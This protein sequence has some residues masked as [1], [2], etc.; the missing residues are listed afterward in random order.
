MDEPPAINRTVNLNAGAGNDA[1]EDLLLAGLANVDDRN[2]LRPQ[3]AEALPTIENGLWRLLPDGRMETTWRLRP[4]A[5]WHDGA[6]FSANDLLFTAR[7]GQDR[8]LPIRRARVF[9]LIDGFDAPDPQTLKVSWKRT[10]IYADTLF[11]RT[12]LPPMPEH[13]LGQAYA[14]EKPAFAHLPYWTQE[15]VGTGPFRVRDWVRGSHVTLEANERYV[16]GRPRVDQVEVRFIPDQNAL[17]ASLLAGAVELTLGRSLTLDPAIQVRDQWRAGTMELGFVNWF[18]IYPQLLTPSPGVIADVQLRRALLHAIDRQQMVESLQAG[19]ATVAHTR[20]HPSEPEYAEI[21]PLVARYD[22]DPR[23]AAQIIEG[24]GYTKGADGLYRDG[25][26]QR[27]SVE[28]RSGAGD[29]LTEK[30]MLSVADFWKRLG[31]DA[32]PFVLPPERDR[33]AEFRA[34]FPGF[35][36]IRQPNDPSSLEDFRSSAAPLPET[37]YQGRNRPRYINPEWD[38][39]IERHFTT[40]ARAE[41]TQ[42]LAQIESHIADRLIMMGLYYNT[43]PILFGNR[44]LNVTARKASDSTHSWNAEH[45]EIR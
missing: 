25:A 27:L 15:F 34:I 9:D 44:L 21:A 30:S 10:F 36:M 26:N 1:L 11:T 32:E 31:V 41:R 7:V 24:L 17:S 39:L 2:Q 42:V 19:L 4:S 23:R 38:A 29:D 43:E 20:I 18:V 5:Q 3:L 40:V 22:Y 12:V 37:R 14:E 13:L 6:P 8:E 45:W 28:V 33:D 35:W 16:L